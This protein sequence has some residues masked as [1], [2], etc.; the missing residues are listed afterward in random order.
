MYIITS[1]QTTRSKRADGGGA[2]GHF[3]SCL[4]RSRFS[5]F[6]STPARR[7][8]SLSAKSAPFFARA[9]LVRLEPTF[10]AGPLRFL[11]AAGAGG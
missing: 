2:L 9:S 1:L 11:L 3:H 8:S 6:T 7:A 5:F 10:F 4:A